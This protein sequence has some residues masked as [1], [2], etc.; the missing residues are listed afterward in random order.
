MFSS[1]LVVR[2]RRPLTPATFL[3]LGASANAS[4]S[5]P[6]D[7]ES[8]LFNIH[9]VIKEAITNARIAKTYFDDDMSSS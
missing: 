6:I 4:S 1:A 2:A 9:E 3:R 5:Y 7:V 8:L